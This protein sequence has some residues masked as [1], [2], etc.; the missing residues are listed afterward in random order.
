M[1]C[2]ECKE[3][4]FELIERE[5]L[6]P[7]GVR[8][9]LARCPDCRALFDEMQVALRSAA[10]LPREEPPA[11]I[12]AAIVRAARERSTKVAPPER[13]WFQA[14]QWAVAAA[15]LLAVGVGVWSIPRGE[16]VAMDDAVVSPGDGA[17]NVEAERLPGEEVDI[18]TM[19]PE[20]ATIERPRGRERAQRLAASESGPAPVV[21]ARPAPDQRAKRQLARDADSLPQTK[22]AATLKAPQATAAGASA[23]MAAIEEDVSEHAVKK[24]Q[25]AMSTE[26]KKRISELDALIEEHELG[27]AALVSAEDALALGHCYREAGDTAQARSWF[28]RAALDS[29]TKRRALRALRALPPN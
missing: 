7:E 10:A 6:D 17:P 22:A 26:C 3:Q 28:E 4:V 16:E 19:Q 24:E 2:D 13:K 8:E 25:K 11:R 27:A 14:P 20:A 5:A 15:A 18:A 29:K 23:D 21:S 1:N 9:V 12:D